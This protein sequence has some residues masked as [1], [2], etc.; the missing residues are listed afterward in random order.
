MPQRLRVRLKIITILFSD[1]RDYFLNLR[2]VAEAGK[3]NN[4]F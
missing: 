4:N 2:P 3:E 1:Y